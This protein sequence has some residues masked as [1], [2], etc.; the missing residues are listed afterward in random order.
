MLTYV[1]AGESHGPQL[2]AVLTG[3]P[4]GLPISLDKINYQLARRQTGYGRG[5][6][7]KI[8]S[9]Q[10]QILSG[11]RHGFTLGSPVTLVITNKDWPNWDKIMHPIEPI[12][13]DLN[14]K[15]KRLA[16]QTRTPRPGHADLSGGIKHNHHD[17][18]NVLERAS[19]R[20]TAARVAVG[21]VTRQLLEQFDVKLA[22]H[23]L[24]IGT[25]LLETDY[26]PNDLDFIK[27]K[28]ELSEVRCIDPTTETKMIEEIKAAQKAKDSLGGVVEVLIS[29]LPAGLGGYA[30]S[31]DRLDGKLA[32][33]MMSIQSVKAVEV[34]LG[35]EASQLHGSEVHDEIFFDPKGDP[36]RKNFY[37]RTN[38][39]GGLEGGMTT[40]ETV[41]LHVGCKPISTLNRPL[42]TV[43]VLSKQPAQAMV[44]RTDNCVVPALGVVCEAVSALV[45]A[46]CFLDKYG[47]DNYEETRRNYQAWLDWEY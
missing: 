3:I 38:R 20:E 23:V 37:R 35:F 31:S 6:R 2:T 21:A 40:G 8:E 22:S 16:E 33:A 5:G 19:A 44:E 15:E 12:S 41:V 7:M 45:L 9:D 34:G 46:D 4:A 27:D 47:S 24:R 10:A 29:G 17:L 30:Q 1:T 42:E 13:F 26:D 14:L 36:R 39:A 11:V 25:V 28:S 32:G 18:R 43:D